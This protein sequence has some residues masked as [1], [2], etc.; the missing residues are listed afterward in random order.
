[1]VEY[2]DNSNPKDNFCVSEFGLRQ[3][4]EASFPLHGLKYRNGCHGHYF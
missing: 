1:M 3:T 4:N 2:P